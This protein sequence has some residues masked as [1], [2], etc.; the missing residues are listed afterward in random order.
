MKKKVLIIANNDVGLY[1]FRKELIVDLLDNY[2]VFCSLPRGE[3]VQEFVDMGCTFCPVE[4]DRHGTN[5]L[6]E[7]KLLRQYEKTLKNIKPDIVLTYTIKPNIYGG[8]VCARNHIPYIS[9]ITGL[10]TAVENEGIL[11]KVTTFLYRHALRKSQKVFFQ[12][13]EN[14]SFMKRKKI[15]KT[16]YDLLPGSGVNLQQHQLSEYPDKETVDFM[17]VA[18]VMKEKGIE[19]Y[20]EAADVIRSKYPFSHFHICGACEQDY[21][22]KIFKLQEKGIVEYHGMVK[23][24]TPL[25]QMCDCVVHPT[26]YPEGLSNVLLEASATGRPII[27][28][29]RS[30]CREV[31]EDGFNGYMIPQKN[32]EALINAI[33]KFLSLTQEE[34]KQMG[35]NAR[36]KVEKEFDRNIVVEKYME[37]IETALQREKNGRV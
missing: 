19:H 14:L 16:E 32:T 29:D 23:D 31:V 21:E 18:R 24:M 12:N 36:T 5:I 28:T 1:K 4:F 17:F 15:L 7:L 27:T 13:E 9:N 3:F 8:I 34:R 37:E 35:L 33:E 22:G 2:E 30:G 20:L 25:Y 11:Q 10:G 26:Y 6:N